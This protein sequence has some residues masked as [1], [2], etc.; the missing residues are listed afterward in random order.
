MFRSC[1]FAPL[2]RFTPRQKGLRSTRKSTTLPSRVLGLLHPS[3]GQG[4]L[5]F[6]FA[7]TPT[8]PSPKTASLLSQIDDAPH[9]A[10][11]TPRRSPLLDSRSA[12]LR[13]LPPCC[14]AFVNP[15]AVADKFAAMTLNFEALLRPKVRREKHRIAGSPHALLPWALF[16]SK[17]L[18]S[19]LRDC[20]ADVS[21][22]CSPPVSTA[23][24]TTSLPPP[25][26]PTAVR[27][28]SE[29]HRAASNRTSAARPSCP[30]S[31]AL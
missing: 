9:S 3:T 15:P 16:P 5:C 4:S 24:A 25:C 26:T 8:S 18:E 13:P 27:S 17:V 20:P 29:E 22:R 23:L 2:Q 28:R 19:R 21:I 10:V 14:C 1:G 11:H 6:T 30:I 7:A 12:S 31:R